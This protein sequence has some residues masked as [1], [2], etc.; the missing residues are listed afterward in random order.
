MLHATSSPAPL[1]QKHEFEAPADIVTHYDPYGAPGY[2]PSQQSYGFDQAQEPLFGSPQMQNFLSTSNFP[3]RSDLHSFTGEA[4][5]L[6]S[7]PRGDSPN[8][9]SGTL[10]HI[11][12]SS[13]T[14][15]KIGTDNPSTMPDT[16]SLNTG[17]G[18]GQRRRLRTSQEPRK[19]RLPYS[20][21][22]CESQ[23]TFK[24]KNEWKRH[25]RSHVPQAEYTCLPEG[26]VIPSDDGRFV[27][28]ICGLSEP[29]ADHMVK[30]RMHLCLYKSL[31]D[32][33]WHRKDK[34]GKHLR[35]VV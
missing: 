7:T 34:F 9:S 26:A 27:C 14:S 3:H 2:H 31:D 22:F 29:R 20:C 10:L 19:S 24:S 17:G 25:E 18:Y 5:S 1:E 12:S 16:R 33:T 15:H 4:G 21:T 11:A 6:R 23:S 13:A 28:A 30:H 32:R 35:S 8:S